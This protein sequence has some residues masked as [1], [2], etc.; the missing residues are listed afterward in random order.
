M[1]LRFINI[2]DLKSPEVSCNEAF[3]NEKP[4][5]PER[6]MKLLK[7]MGLKTA[8]MALRDRSVRHGDELFFIFRHR[9]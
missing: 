2:S 7:S 1:N 4:F 3:Y 6:G 9:R 8:A 5:R